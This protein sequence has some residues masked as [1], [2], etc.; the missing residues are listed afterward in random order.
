MS[1][2]AVS[3]MRRGTCDVDRLG[4]CFEM[5]RVHT[6]SHTAF[7]V[8]LQSLRDRPFVHLIA[9][10]MS[11]DGSAGA[12]PKQAVAALIEIPGPQ[13]A[14]RIWLRVDKR[15]EPLVGIRRRLPVA[16]LGALLGPQD[17]KLRQIHRSFCPPTISRPN[18]S[19]TGQT[20]PRRLFTLR[21]ICAC[22][23]Y[24]LSAMR[25]ID[26][27]LLALLTF[28]AGLGVGANKA[29]PAVEAASGVR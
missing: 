1:M 29:R 18:N 15:H 12:Y 9:E 19:T 7:V 23:G 2:L 10:A 14:S 17:A 11:A 21:A 25:L 3:P 8:S 26:A 13:P 27:L 16:L 6:T 20:G 28:A 5:V 24:I 4:H 22:V